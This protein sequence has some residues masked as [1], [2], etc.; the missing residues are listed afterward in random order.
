MKKVLA[1]I[2][3]CMMMISLVAC[4]KSKE[5]EDATDGESKGEEYDVVYL[6][7]STESEYWQYAEVG[8]QNAA[9]DIA[10]EKGIKINFS[11]SGPATE[12][13]TDAY[14]KAYESVIASS[15]DAIITATLA[16]DG[17]VPKTQ[18]A[19]NAGIYV[20]FVSMGLEGGDSNEYGDY[21]GVH[22]YCNNTVIGETAA[23]AMLDGL[24][25]AGIEPKG[26]IGMHMSVVVERL[27]GF[28]AYMAEHAPEIEC[29]DTLYNENDVN[30]AQSNVETQIS[31][32][33]DELIGLYGGN[34]VSGDGIA[35]GLKN[36]GEGKKILGIGVDSDSIEIEALKEGNLYAIIVQTPYEQGYMAMENAIEYLQ[37]GK[38]PETEKH[39]DCTSQVVTAEN[40]DSDE[41]KA[42]LD[43]KILKK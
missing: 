20:N 21:Y 40:M 22:Y 12:A 28:K 15:P 34:N 25:A 4:S 3:T 6:S 2:L 33:G 14:I 31:T 26:K 30:N 11:T 9:I 42:L 32:Y 43:P 13:E 8:M 5:A 19:Q 7:P 17:T 29:L 39:I 1:V 16:P 38:N 24:E 41:S 27:D 23:K 18:E 36:V 37:T 35:L 10:E